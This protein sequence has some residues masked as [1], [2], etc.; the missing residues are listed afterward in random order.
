MKGD[1]FTATR[2]VG[3]WE[4]L[5]EYLGASVA[6]MSRLKFSNNQD[7]IMKWECLTDVFNNLSPSLDWE[8]VVGVVGNDSINNGREACKIAK[9][10]IGMEETECQC[11]I[12][13]HES[14]KEDVKGGIK[15]KIVDKKQVSYYTVL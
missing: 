3:D 12:S 8:R 5:C 13:A 1:L 14:S 9:K 10:Y 2:N 11:I 6:I 15:D 4:G 7:I